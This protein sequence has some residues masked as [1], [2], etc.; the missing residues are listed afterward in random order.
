MEDRN[1]RSVDDRL[2]EEL[3]PVS[4]GAVS[5]PASPEDNLPS[6]EILTGDFIAGTVEDYT[7]TSKRSI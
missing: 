5:R 7:S 2:A 6:T 3:R 1:D 4:L